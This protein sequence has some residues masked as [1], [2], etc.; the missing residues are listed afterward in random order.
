MTPELISLFGDADT[1]AQ[2]LYKTESAGAYSVG[3]S[4]SDW[5]KSF[6]SQGGSTL[7]D[8]FRSLFSP[9]MQS[10]QAT[11]QQQNLLLIGGVGVAVVVGVI[12]LTRGARGRRR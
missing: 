6:A 10:A 4:W 9:Q 11:M 3:S 12:L 2:Q 1:S 5:L 7:S 8:V